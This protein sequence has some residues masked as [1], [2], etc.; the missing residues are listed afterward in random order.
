MAQ[1]QWPREV[2]VRDQAAGVSF[3]DGSQC[4][5]AV[6]FRTARTIEH[7][8]EQVLGKHRF[9]LARIRWL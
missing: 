4:A 3:L 2:R 1:R 8:G 6:S 7:L 9:R 5:A